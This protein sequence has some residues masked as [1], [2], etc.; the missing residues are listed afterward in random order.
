MDFGNPLNKPTPCC[1][2]LRCKSMFYRADERPGLL[3]HEDAMTYWCE[4]TNTPLGPDDEGVVHPECQSGRACY[5]A[6]PS[7]K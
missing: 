6:G 3:H 2:H 1:V 7:A 5:K 4:H